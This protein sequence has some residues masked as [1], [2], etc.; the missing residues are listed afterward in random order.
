MRCP[1]VPHPAVKP[2]HEGR[3]PILSTT[4]ARLAASLVIEHDQKPIGDR[5]DS[6]TLSRTREVQ[7]DVEAEDV[8]EERRRAEDPDPLD[9]DA[10]IILQG[11]SKRYPAEV[12]VTGLQLNSWGLAPAAPAVLYAQGHCPHESFGSIVTSTRMQ[13]SALRAGRD[14]GKGCGAE[15]QHGDRA[16]RG[17]RT[18]GSQW[19]RC[20]PGIMSRV[21]RACMAGCA[22]AEWLVIT[23]PPCGVWQS[24]QMLIQHVGVGGCAVK[25]GSI[26]TQTQQCHRQD[27]GAAAHDGLFGA[28]G[29]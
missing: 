17:V 5:A 27:D 28:V 16:R 24:T 3:F 13:L 25:R 22:Q 2:S 12:R 18:S 10:C 11:L 8:A 20:C 9:E 23:Q 15:P 29:R 4:S 7:I 1:L 21:A 14:T 6:A 26:L 19:R